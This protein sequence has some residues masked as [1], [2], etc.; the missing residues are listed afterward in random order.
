[1]RVIKLIM[2]G[3]FFIIIIAEFS[4]IIRGTLSLGRS[5]LLVMISLATL[6]Y[7]RTRYSWGILLIL[8]LGGIYSMVALAPHSSIGVPMDF[9]NAVNYHLFNGYT[10]SILFRIIS[11]F[12]LAFYI[13]LLILLFLK[14]VKK[15]YNL[16]SKKNANA[17]TF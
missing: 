1:M 2:L 5:H 10:S 16:I 13:V 15:H 12:P 11:F 7:F 9:T 8:C 3:L 4:F 17:S 14:S 6:L